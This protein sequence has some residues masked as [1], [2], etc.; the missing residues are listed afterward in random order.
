MD[1]DELGLGEGKVGHL[2]ARKEMRTAVGIKMVDPDEPGPGLQ[3]MEH[4]GH[5]LAGDFS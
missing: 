5:A 3:I 1:P 2:A 4:S